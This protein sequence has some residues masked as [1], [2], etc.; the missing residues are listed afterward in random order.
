MPSEVNPCLDAVASRR[1]LSDDLP[2]GLVSEHDAE[3]LPAESVREPL[4]LEHGDLEGLAAE[5]RVE[6]RVDRSP[7]AFEH[8]QIGAV[9]AH[10][11]TQ[12]KVNVSV[13]R[14]PNFSKL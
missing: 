11:L 1:C 5:G 4:V 9:I 8:D 13:T 7:H 10:H 12:V 14:I 3:H 2:S 6:I